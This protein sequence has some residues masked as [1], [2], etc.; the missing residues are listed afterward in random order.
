ML[1]ESDISDK[2]HD[3][4]HQ[5]LQKYQVVF[6]TSSEDIGY[7]ELITMDIDTGLTETLHPPIETS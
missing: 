7:T 6:S 4:F 3:K 5:L 2:T 1:P